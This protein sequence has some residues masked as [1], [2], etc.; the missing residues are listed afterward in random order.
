MV[1]TFTFNQDKLDEDM[2][3]IKISFVGEYQTFPNKLKER[4]DVFM[5]LK[6]HQD[7]KKN[8][9]FLKTILAS[10]EKRLLSI[11]YFK[12]NVSFSLTLDNDNLVYYKEN[13]NNNEYTYENNILNFKVNGYPKVCELEDVFQVIKNISNLKPLTLSEEDQSLIKAYHIFYNKYPDFTNKN[14]L[15]E[16]KNMIIILQ[17]FQINLKFKKPLNAQVNRLFLFGIID[18]LD[19]DN[20]LTAQKIKYIG[21]K[22]RLYKNTSY[23]F[24]KKRKPLIRSIKKD[25][26]F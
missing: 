22:I 17:L 6:S 2:G 21:Q 13:R 23:Q 26:T 9:I 8:I 24:I 20:D 15:R 7:I 5:N 19:D 4:L 16:M 10:F 1:K 11:S 12:D 3:I 14:I 18:Y 25:L